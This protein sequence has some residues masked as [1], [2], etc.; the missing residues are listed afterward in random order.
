ME[1]I[2]LQNPN[3]LPAVKQSQKW[4]RENLE[5]RRRSSLTLPI[6]LCFL[7]F[8]RLQTG[9]NL[10]KRVGSQRLPTFFFA[11][12]KGRLGGSPGLLFYFFALLFWPTSFSS[13]PAPTYPPLI[14]FYF[15]SELNFAS[16]PLRG[17]Q[18]LFWL[19][20]RGSEAAPL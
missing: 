4:S 17:A 20:S 16:G 12:H 1:A 11:T 6:S 7:T 19:V 5:K 15:S 2:S 14:L 18:V 10:P 8:L 13:P 3:F 9:S